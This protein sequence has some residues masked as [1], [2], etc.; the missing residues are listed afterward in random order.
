M[1][2]T[3]VSDSYYPY[4]SGVTRAVATMKDTLTRMGH[5]VTVFCPSYPGT[6]PEEGVVRFPSFRAPT[7]KTYYVAVPM[8]FR[9]RNE[10]SRANPD[11]I[12]I[13][14]PFNLCAA[15]L[16][17]ARRMGIPVV[18]TYHT[19]YNMY[20]HYVPVVGPKMS[21][22]V[23]RTALRVARSADAVITPSATIARYLH[24]KDPA[25]NP[26]PI[27]N[28]IPVAEFQT[29]DP[30][31]LHETYG[32]PKGQVVLTSGRLGLEK[33]L[34]VLLKAFAEIAKKTEANLVLVG[35][36]PL[37]ETLK[38]EARSLG[39]ADRAFFIGT[40][41]PDK[42]PSVY[43]GADLFLFTSL[44]D[45]QG[46]VLVEA[47]AAGLPAVAVGALGVND[48]VEDGVDGY[49]CKN[50]PGELAEKASS[51]LRDEKRL[52]EMSQNAKRN[53]QAFSREA[54]A[55]RLLRCYESVIRKG[56]AAS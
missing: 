51:L 30:G 46:L 53:A 14:S 45:T 27:P 34:S 20:S 3:M 48:M 12:H 26:L 54:C 41:L 18:M 37:R 44:T 42:M 55:E 7:N 5:N 36:G 10:I 1:R 24:G 21:T 11:V 52:E 6:P 40:V 38:E 17:A 35:D 25:V 33:N 56:S 31:F 9:I 32:I 23:E 29:G 4:V 49:L 15:A 13:H 22:L 8:Y 43:A 28:G 47:K 2:I 16:R 39:V 50:D 19:M